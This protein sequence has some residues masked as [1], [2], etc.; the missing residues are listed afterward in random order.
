MA[1]FWLKQKPDGSYVIRGQVWSGRQLMRQISLAAPTQQDVSAT[2]KEVAEELR[3]LRTTPLS[4]ED[5]AG[6][7]K[8]AS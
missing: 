3:P 6:L 8:G 1:K 4:A 7:T 2:M 5:S